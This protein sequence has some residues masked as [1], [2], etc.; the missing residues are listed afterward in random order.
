MA[1]T[2]R[3]NLSLQATHTKAED[4]GT[5]TQ[6]LSVNQLVEFGSGTGAGNINTKWS[7][8]RTLGASATEDI[9]LSGS[10]TDVFG[11][12]VVNA[13]VKVFYAKAAAANTNN[14]VFATGESNGWATPWGAGDLVLR[15]GEW[16]IFCVGVADAT[17]HAVAGGSTDILKVTN[18]AGSTSVTYD[19][20]VLGVSS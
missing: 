17:G 6:P 2:A 9:D 1:L 18:S 14:V 3:V 20:V 4:L 12:S 15:P 16:V 11:A 7:D 10:L 5:A 19:I 8:T 13:R